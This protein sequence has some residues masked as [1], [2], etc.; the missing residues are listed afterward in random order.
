LFCKPTAAE[1]SRCLQPC[2]NTQLLHTRLDRPM[3]SELRGPWFQ[4]QFTS[5]SVCTWHSLLTG[6]KHTKHRVDQDTVDEALEWLRVAILAMLLMGAAV[7]LAVT[8]LLFAGLLVGDWGSRP[9]SWA[10]VLGAHT[11]GRHQH[12]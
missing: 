10:F 11:V 12:T 9:Q 5:P 3:H 4:L 1:H 2:C 7:L 8:A 6:T